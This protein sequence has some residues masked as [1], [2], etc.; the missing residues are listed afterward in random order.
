[1]KVE[2]QWQSGMH[3]KCSSPSNHIIDVDWG[4]NYSDTHGPAPMELLLHAIASCTGMDIVFILQKK[5]KKLEAFEVIVEGERAEK[6]PKI[7]TKV[8]MHYKLQGDEL[9]DKEVE[10][11]IS[12]SLDKYCSATAMIIPKAEVTWD[13]ELNG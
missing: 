9:T 8:K 11:A 3:F 1:M 13:Y 6:H 2:A 12:L 5:R 7:F 4:L 10:Q